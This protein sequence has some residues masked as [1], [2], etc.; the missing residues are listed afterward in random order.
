VHVKLNLGS[1]PRQAVALL[2]IVA[3]IIMTASILVAPGARAAPEQEP[4]KLAKGDS[5]MAKACAEGGIRKA[6]EV[7][8]GLVR[9]ARKAGVKMECDECHKDPT[10]YEVLAD[11]ARDK[12]KNLMQAAAPPGK[13]AGK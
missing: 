11:D 10:R 1:R 6:K 3:A 7:M 13:S 4:C 5:P 8:K 2:A 12:L 9:D